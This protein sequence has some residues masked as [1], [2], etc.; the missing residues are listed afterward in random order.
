V[1]NSSGIDP[2]V[3]ADT[4][5][6]VMKYHSLK[7]EEINRIIEELWKSTYRGTDVDTILIRSDNENAKGNRSY[8]YRVRYWITCVRNLTAHFAFS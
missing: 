4:I 1:R 7:M 3:P 6:A 8:N 2:N 5:R